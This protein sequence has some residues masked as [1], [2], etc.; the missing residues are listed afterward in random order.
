MGSEMCIRD[1][2]MCSDTCW[3]TND[4]Q[5]RG[6]EASR[7]L[8]LMLTVETQGRVC[9]RKLVSIWPKAVVRKF[10]LQRVTRRREKGGNEQRTRM[11]N[12]RKEMK[13]S[14]G[15][16]MGVSR[17][18]LDELEDQIVQRCL[19]DGVS[20]TRLYQK[21]RVKYWKKTV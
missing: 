1:R 13:T 15:M 19:E 3:T 8:F 10:D 2:F 20:L 6:K 16:V 12:S 11:K 17:Y 14:P 9:G 4:P 18:T 21:I 5:Y 7:D